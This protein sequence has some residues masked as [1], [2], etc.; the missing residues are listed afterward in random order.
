GH[1]Y[2]QRNIV[3]LLKIISD[4][5]KKSF[6]KNQEFILKIFGKYDKLF[7]KKYIKRLGIQDQVYLGEYLTR[8]RIFEEI[9]ECNLAVHIG[10]NVNYPTIAFKVW[11]YLSCRKKI[12]YLGREDS[13][14]AQ[15]LKKNN[16]GIIIPINNINEG[17]KIFEELLKD[18]KKSNFA[19]LIEKE[20]L[21]QY[22]W[23][24]IVDKFRL[25]VENLF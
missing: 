23:D 22:S 8:S 20:K 6:F 12:L 13:Y 10:E 1:L 17:K 15:F 21:V 24:N 11:D 14:T 2:G 9:S 3:P 7:L 25:C 5:K 18:L 4:L 19:N 16:F